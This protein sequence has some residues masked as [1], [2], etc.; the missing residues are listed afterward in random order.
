MRQRP[1]GTA[2]RK[3]LAPGCASDSSMTGVAEESC[4]CEL[5]EPALHSM[6]E[7]L[8]TS[9]H[10]HT[11][12]SS[13]ICPQGGAKSRRLQWAEYHPQTWA[14]PQSEHQQG[15][16]AAVGDRGQ[17]VH[18]SRLHTRLT[19]CQKMLC[20][21]PRRARSRAQG[22]VRLQTRCSWSAGWRCG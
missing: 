12:C 18:Q 22:S 20:W 8:G 14:P 3:A 7:A 21:E 17:L 11:Q 2:A 6:H 4:L 1:R 15:G 5:A 10:R 19:S 13:S 16:A 9:R